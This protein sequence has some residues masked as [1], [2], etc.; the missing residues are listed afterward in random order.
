MTSLGRQGGL[1]VFRTESREAVAVLH[2]NRRDSGIGK[3]THEPPPP[4]VEA[5]A[6]LC[7]RRPD[8][9]SMLGRPCGETGDLALQIG[10]LIV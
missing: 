5:G 4:T 9:V 10:P 6:D 7:L 3:Q 8:R 2:N 1:D